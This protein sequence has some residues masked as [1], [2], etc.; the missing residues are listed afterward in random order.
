MMA[1]TIG[2]IVHY[3]SRT[4]NYTCPAIVTATQDTLWRE[5]VERGD[6]PELTGP[7]DV[8]LHVFTPGA[9]GSYSEHNVPYAGEAPVLGEFAGQPPRS[10]TWPPIVERKVT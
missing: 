7:M 9:Q 6:V 2:R 8:H 5:G 1:P 10:W 3:R 4:G